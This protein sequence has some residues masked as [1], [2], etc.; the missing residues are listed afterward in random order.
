MARFTLMHGCALAALALAT[1][2]AAAQLSQ[3]D[4]PA[5]STPVAEQNDTGISDIV[6][7]A[8]KREQSVLDVPISMEVVSGDQLEAF[9]ASDVKS[10]MNYVPNVFVQQTAGNDVIYVRGF[11]SPPA[12]FSFDQAVSLYADGVYAGKVRQAQ[13]PFF[14]VERVEV[15]RGPQ[16]ALFG[17]N[18]AAGA[19][20]VVS[21][22]PT[23]K[24]SGGINV[25]YNFDQE[26]YDIDGYVAGPV[27]DT[28][29][30]RI[31]VRMQDQ[32]GWIT[33]RFNGDKEPRMRM[34]LVRGTLRWAPTGD[35][36]TT[37]KVEYSNV[38]RD[39]G[40]N[41]SSVLTDQVPR[42]VRYGAPGALS[43]EL[44]KNESVLLSNT[45]NLRL[46]EWTLTSVT[47][48]SWYDGNVVNGFDQLTPAGTITPN[49]TYNSYPENYDQF[50]Q[51]LRLQS[52]VGRPIELLVGA[53]YDDH[54]YQVDQLGGFNIASLNYFGLLHTIFNQTGNSFSAFGQATWNATDWFRAIGSL[55]WTTVNKEGYFRGRLE[56]GPYALRPVNT[57]ARG[58]FNEDYLDPSLTL[59]LDATDDIMLY[60]SYGR[61]SKSG[62]F[63]SNTYGTTDATFRYAPERS[64]NYEVGVKASL[65][66]RAAVVTL[67]AYDTKFKNLQVSVYNPTTSSYLTGNAASATSRGVEGSLMLRPTRWFEISGS[68]AYLDIK[69]DDYPGAACLASQP[70]TACNPASPASIAANNL[71]GYSPAYTSDWSGSVRAH[72]FFDV[73]SLRFDATGIAAGRSGYYNSDNQSPT[74]GYQEGYVKYD[75]RLE[76][77]SPDQGWKVALVGRNLTNELTVS[78]A[79]N[80]P[81]PI[82]AVPRAILYVE[83][84]RSIAVEVGFKF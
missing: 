77:S 28:L 10:I 46:G 48:Y 31:A 82:T 14:D 13:A 3:P 1:Q 80:L 70:I 26:G 15:L 63:V 68:G 47:G 67:S 16:G 66:E 32:D 56:Y 52:P 34:N 75:A 55:R 20:S 9:K 7:T 73:G 37:F 4:A 54:R 41:V 11:G 35:F 79:F 40:L 74:F 42:L 60:A 29:G 51:E 69:Y 18:T 45:A 8:T 25:A 38:Q 5:V 33:N 49:S 64:R 57:V 36:D 53:F 81:A 59:Q 58:D 21:A 2:P 84:P 19:V 12:N 39:G 27:T 61:G 23:A 24:V 62:G 6:V 44:Y 72:A 71:A 76:M 17:K 65:F 83:Q 30:A 22:G 50:S 78:S 43:D